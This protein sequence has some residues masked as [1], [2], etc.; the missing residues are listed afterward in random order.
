MADVAREPTGSAVVTGRPTAP[1]PGPVEYAAAV[2]RYLADAALGSA[3]RRVYRISLIGW[4]WPLVGLEPPAGAFRRGA[5]PPVVPLA[6]FD[7]D[8]A[9]DKLASAVAARSLRVDVSTVNR[10]LSA[11]HS[12]VGWW[13]D[14]GWIRRDPTAGLRT[15][16][17]PAQSLVPLTD[18]QVA[19]L[20]SIRASLREQALWHLL[21]DTGMAAP[22]ALGLDAAAINRAGRPTPRAPATL[23][24][25]SGWSERTAELLA[26]LLSGR[27]LGPVFLTERKA[28]GN[29]A[30]ADVCPLTGRARMSYR[31]AAEIFSA[32]TKPIDPS[33]HGWTLRQ[34]RPVERATPRGTEPLIAS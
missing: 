22:V 23:I 31:R 7:D 32:S 13:Q 9:A 26:W 4:A 10:E 19:A 3:S 15:L 1:R 28:A 21:R 25:E 24:E 14:M 34:L 2:D 8:D 12:A 27:S 30:R 29:A 17:G 11:L 5:R 33:G 18:Q 16:P 20:F 6:V